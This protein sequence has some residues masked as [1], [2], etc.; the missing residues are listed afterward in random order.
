MLPECYLVGDSLI[1]HVTAPMTRIVSIP[2]ADSEFVTNAA[3][4]M[5]G[6]GV[7]LLFVVTGTNDFMQKDGRFGTGVNLVRPLCSRDLMILLLY[8]Y[9]SFIDRQK[10][11]RMGQVSRYQ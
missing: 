3:S 2:G 11:L 4:A 1:K 7:K 10:G 8:D 9:L 5:A 6:P